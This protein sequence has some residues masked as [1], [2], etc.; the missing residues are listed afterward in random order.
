MAVQW[1][2][3][4]KLQSG[5]RITLVVCAGG[6]AVLWLVFSALHHAL[7]SL[8]SVD[9]GVFTTLLEVIPAVIVA[10]AI[11]AA[12]T[13]FVIAQL[14]SSALGSRAVLALLTSAVARS[15]VIAGM[16][17]LLASLLVATLADLPRDPVWTLTP[18]RD[19]EPQEIV[20]TA[21]QDP[22]S[23]GLSSAAVTLSAATGVYVLWAMRILVAVV[24]TFVDPKAYSDD[25]AHVRIERNERKVVEDLY[26]RV[27]ALRQWLRTAAAGGES[28][29]LAF[30]LVGLE[31]L[32]L[33]YQRASTRAGIRRLVPREYET[34]RILDDDGRRAVA[35]GR[36]EHRSLWLDGWFGAE[37]GRALVRGLEVGMRGQLLRRDADRILNALTASVRLTTVELEDGNATPREALPDDAGYLIDR[38]TEAGLLFRQ[39]GQ[40]RVWEGWFRNPAG[41]LADLEAELERTGLCSFGPTLET[42]DTE[43][44]PETHAPCP[45]A[46]RAL[47]GWCAVHQALGDTLAPDDTDR[48]GPRAASG[49]MVLWDAARELAE[50]QAVFPSWLPGQ[51]DQNSSSSTVGG[52]SLTQYVDTMHQAV[53][54]R[55]KPS[56]GVTAPA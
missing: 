31:G 39:F 42:R 26:E 9:A 5:D 40:G 54:T 3:A 2:R 19:G 11:F 44:L 13:I 51:T 46:A 33:T 10:V 43:D 20:A 37:L 17:L 35:L 4:S 49:D 34:T 52:T 12:G 36:R 41:K 6:L 25:L 45:L 56:S 1:V 22:L 24:W 53:R 23:E 38:L 50:E 30:S 21:N 29:D 27:R 18:A 8:F 55:T 16:L 47:V 15:G 48:L 28:R 7:P 32:L 14:I